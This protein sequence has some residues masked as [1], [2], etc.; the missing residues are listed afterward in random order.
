MNW[1]GYSGGFTIIELII[2]MVITATLLTLGVAGVRTLQAYARDDERRADVE[3]I[4]RGL[5]QRYTR[6]NPVASAPS[7]EAQRGSYPGVNEIVHVDGGNRSVQGYSPAQYASEYRTLELPG[8]QTSNFY[9][10]QDK[11]WRLLCSFCPGGTSADDATLVNSALSEDKYVY[12]PA[13]ASDEVCCCGNCTH[14][15]IFWRSEVD[16]TIQTLRSKRQ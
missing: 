14:F 1:R 3:A 13:N 10:P 6:G 5:E 9:S 15:Y 2:V 12:S 7:P 4:A 16:G 11:L 8:T